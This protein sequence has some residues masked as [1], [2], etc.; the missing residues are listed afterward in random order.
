MKRRRTLDARGNPVVERKNA[1]GI[2]EVDISQSAMR[3][4]DLSGFSVV[5]TG[6]QRRPDFQPPAHMKV[7]TSPY[8]GG[9]INSAKKLKQ[10]S[11]LDYMRALSEEIIRKREESKR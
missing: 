1:D 11:S 2:Y 8:E 7:G 3:K 10:R 6:S 4:I 9:A 5:D